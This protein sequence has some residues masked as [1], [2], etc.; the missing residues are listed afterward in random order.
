MKIAVEPSI[1]TVPCRAG[2][3]WTPKQLFRSGAVGAWFDLSDRKTLFQDAAGTEPVTQSGQ[4]VGLI[5]DKSG[6]GY[7]LGQAQPSARP[8]FRCA[9]GLSWLEFDGVDDRLVFEKPIDMNNGTLIA[10]V[11]ES[12]GRTAPVALLSAAA[13]GYLAI[14]N[15]GASRTLAKNNGG[16]LC[17]V[18]TPSAF[19]MTVAAP[20]QIRFQGTTIRASR[21]SNRTEFSNSVT[22]AAGMTEVRYFGAFSAAGEIP[23]AGKLFGLLC[24]VSQVTETDALKALRFTA[25]RM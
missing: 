20:V 11:V 16:A 4:S 15:S 12:A 7:H 10:G 13:P 8:T 6:N 5:R 23:F 18:D 25:A 3:M 24:L 19:A 21:L 17:S 22:A 9:A 1:A 2:P 14:V